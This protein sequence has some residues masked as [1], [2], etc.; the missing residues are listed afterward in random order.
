MFEFQNPKLSFNLITEI[1]LLLTAV[2]LKLF[3]LKM[4]LL[5]KIVEDSKGLL[6]MAYL[7]M[8]IFQKLRNV[9]NF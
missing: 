4:S 8:F 5:L 1:L 3:G 6:F 7:L 2:V 9:K